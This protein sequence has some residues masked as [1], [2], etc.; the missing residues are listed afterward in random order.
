MENHAPKLTARGIGRLIG[1]TDV[2]VNY[3]LKDQG[4]LYGE[5]GAYGVTPKGK[6]FGVQR[7]HDN[8]YG[9]SAHRSWETTH[10][11]PS[12][13]KVLDSSPEK[14]ATVRRDILTRKQTLS[15]ARKVLQAEAEARFHAFQASKEAPAVEPEIDPQKVWLVIGGIA[16]LVAAGYGAYKGVGWYKRTKAAKDDRNKG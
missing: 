9:G 2:E 15:A 4:F 11:A 5:P 1:A 6:E 10:F 16:I 8:G 7:L 14:L 3:L 13:T 12:I